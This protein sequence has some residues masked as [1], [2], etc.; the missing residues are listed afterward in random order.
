M[1]HAIS[2]PANF[3]TLVSTVGSH[4]TVPTVVLSK[5]PVMKQASTPR[6]KQCSIKREEV[7]AMLAALAESS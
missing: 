1:K 3:G 5:N 4:G 7:E 6:I 2:R